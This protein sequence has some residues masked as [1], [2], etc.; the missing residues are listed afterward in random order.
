MSCWSS[1]TLNSLLAHYRTFQ[2]QAT[3]MNL[4]QGLQSNIEIMRL[5][6]SLVLL[7][8]FR[9]VF[10]ID[11]RCSQNPLL[12]VLIINFVTHR[13]RKNSFNVSKVA[14]N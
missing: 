7:E 4:V 10:G 8:V 1:R 12:N 3:K 5:R 2:Y 11:C 14:S 9:E 13:F 6:Q